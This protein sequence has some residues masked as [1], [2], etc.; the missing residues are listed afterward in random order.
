[1]KGIEIENHVPSF[2]IFCL[3]WFGP[4]P[5]SNGNQTVRP[6]IT[7]VM[8]RR[9]ELSQY[10]RIAKVQDPNPISESKSQRRR[11]ILTMVTDRPS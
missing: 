6:R 1:M 3:I 10:S 2:A 9:T 8:C 7:R 5:L 11:R 4:V